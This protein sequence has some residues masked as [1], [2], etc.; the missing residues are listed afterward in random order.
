MKKVY[1]YLFITLLLS[2]GMISCIDDS[3]NLN[4]FSSDMQIN[5]A[6]PAPIGS[7]RI[8]IADLLANLN[9]DT[10]LLH[11][12]PDDKLLY[13]LYDD[14]IQIE[15]EPIKFK[16]ESFE[17]TFEGV[18]NDTLNLLATAYFMDF[19]EKV[20][21]GEEDDTDKRIDSVLLNVGTLKITIEQNLLSR[22]SDVKIQLIFPNQIRK[23]NRTAQPIDLKVG[24]NNI[25]LNGYLIDFT[26]G[27][28]YFTFE[29]S[30][31]NGTHI[32]LNESSQIKFTVEPA[33]QNLAFQ[34]AWGYFKYPDESE[35]VVIDIFD[36]LKKEDINL[37]F[38]NPKLR[39][40]ATTNLVLPATFSISSIQTVGGKSDVTAEFTVNG[41]KSPSYSI[42]FK[43][44]LAA[45]N[46][47]VSTVNLDKVLATFPDSL[48]FNYGF[49]IGSPNKSTELDAAVFAEGAFIDV[50]FGVELPA[51][52]KNGSFIQL[53]DTVV[54]INLGD[55]IENDFS[56]EKANIYFELE[57]GL[58]LNVDVNFS[59]LDSLNNPV[60]INNP[61]LKENLK[62]VNVTAAS[63]NPAN[64]VVNKT[65][66]ASLKI[67]LDNT[68]TNEIKQC[69]HLVVSYKVDVN[70]SANSVKVTT[71]NFLQAKMS[72]YLKGGIK[73]K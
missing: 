60:V 29:V 56:L 71:D 73:F 48:N 18:E 9:V 72:I 5:V 42:E 52:F 17:R 14:T 30:V 6:L 25:S 13:F 8:T 21:F 33:T 10:D 50:N 20:D 19:K 3:Y 58:P 23:G 47:D 43:N 32:S 44:G 69:K 45:A 11:E 38:Q 22:D 36:G 68:M 28:L 51:W 61:K 64:N 27:D 54:D 7:S 39:L 37:L 59:F 35:K 62:K 57:N 49:E 41:K 1:N 15:L 65:T 67:E 40:A 63:V 31:P 55:L 34:K 12:Y 70:S 16:F 4:E 2:T 24:E 66:K 46:L 26:K 53:T